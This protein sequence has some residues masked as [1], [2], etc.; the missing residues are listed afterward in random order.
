MWEKETFSNKINGF[1]QK[2]E[3]DFWMPQKQERKREKSKVFFSTKSVSGGLFL[4]KRKRFQ[5]SLSRNWR[6]KEASRTQTEVFTHL[7]QIY[8]FSLGTLPFCASTVEAGQ[9]WLRDYVSCVH[10]N[11]NKRSE[12]LEQLIR[13]E[14]VLNKYLNDKLKLIYNYPSRFSEKIPKFVSK[15]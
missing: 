13:I 7:L 10:E 4:H 9:I 14:I 6:V 5:H 15:Q 8:T 12:T 2:H 3:I 1:P 11:V